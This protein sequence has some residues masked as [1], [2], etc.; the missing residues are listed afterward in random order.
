MQLFYKKGEKKYTLEEIVDKYRDIWIDIFNS[1]YKFWGGNSCLDDVIIEA[2]EAFEEEVL[3][4]KG[5]EFFE[6]KF[7]KPTDF[8][9]LL[10]GIWGYPID[11]ESE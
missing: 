8:N 2:A 4:E 1:E 11:K 3:W 9:F 7:N 10:K 6:T 5:Y